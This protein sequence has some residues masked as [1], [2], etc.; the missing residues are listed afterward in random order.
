MRDG[1]LVR[2]VALRAATLLLQQFAG[3]YDFVPCAVTLWPPLARTLDA[4]PAACI[5]NSKPPALLSLIQTT[6]ENTGLIAV[7]QVGGPNVITAAVQCLGAAGA[8][9]SVADSVL[10]IIDSLLVSLLLACAYR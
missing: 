5:G 6:A 8:G 4:L 9:Q 7:L 3:A 10:S 1:A 2:P